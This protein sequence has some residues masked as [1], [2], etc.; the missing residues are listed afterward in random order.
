MPPL[1]AAGI[2]A[3]VSAAAGVL[4]SI[5]SVVAASN[6]S[7]LDQKVLDSQFQNAKR[8]SDTL[9][10]GPSAYYTG[11]GSNSTGSL[12]LGSQTTTM[13]RLSA[14][15]S[16]FGSLSQPSPF[17]KNNGLGGNRNGGI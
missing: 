4:G 5:G 15:N 13:P 2:A 17:M 12:G 8:L 9:N 10:E 3:V 1:G 6:Q 7:G 14:S 11:L 16:S